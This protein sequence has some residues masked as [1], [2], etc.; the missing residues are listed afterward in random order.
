LKRQRPAPSPRR[1][2]GIWMRWSVR[3]A[4]V[5]CISGAPSMTRAR[6]WTS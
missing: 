1:H 4:D 6:F 5:E 3:S 2:V